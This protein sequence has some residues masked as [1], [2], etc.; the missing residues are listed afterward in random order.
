MS[1]VIE[2]KL[3]HC[4]KC[5]KTTKH[6]RNNT[7]T[8][9]V[10][11]L[12]HIVLTVVTAGIWLALLIIYKLLTAKVGGWKCEECVNVGILHKKIF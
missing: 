8:G 2:Q 12:I 9:L 11:I 3:K 4:N 7:T 1:K 10:M 6:H 5:G